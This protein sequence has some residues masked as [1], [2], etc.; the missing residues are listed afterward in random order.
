MSWSTGGFSKELLQ[1]VKIELAIGK[2]IECDDGISRMVHDIVPSYKYPWMVVVNEQDPASNAGY[3]VNLLSLCAQILGKPIPSRESME[4][5]TK[6]MRLSL[7]IN[8]DGSFDRPPLF[9]GKKFFS[10]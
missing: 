6:V 4:A 7:N 9:T 10:A 5:F 2:V 8:E 1:D 3:F